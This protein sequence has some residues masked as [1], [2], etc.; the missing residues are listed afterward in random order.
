MYD[1]TGDADTHNSNLAAVTTGKARL[2]LFID[3]RDVDHQRTPGW[4]TYEENLAVQH[5]QNTPET[6]Y[7]L[8]RR[9]QLHA[10]VSLPSACVFRL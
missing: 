9:R 6:G 8:E 5:S 3:K 2:S 10:G 1:H 4:V 7:R